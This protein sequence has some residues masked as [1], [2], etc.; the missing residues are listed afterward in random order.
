MRVHHG[1]AL[2]ALCLSAGLFATAC[3]KSGTQT[4]ST[5]GTEGTGTTQGQVQ[6]SRIDLGTNVG[7]D[8]VVTE[9]KDAFAPN[10]TVYAS[11]FTSGSAPSAELKTRFTYQDG[12]VVDESTRTI[13]PN[14]QAVTEFHI[15]K[16][17]GFP[18]GKYR[19]EVFVNGAPAA[20]KE[21]EIKNT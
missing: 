11:V 8:N 1:T 16:P 14:G 3:Q 19:V 13:A 18:V 10:E 17:D 12:Q 20:T 2:A 21:F 4:S 5:S 7:N 6:V 9:T 15:S